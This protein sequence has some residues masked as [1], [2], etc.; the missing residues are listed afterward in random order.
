MSEPARST[1]EIIGTVGPRLAD[2]L[3]RRGFVPRFTAR[4]R[5]ALAAVG[6]R[7]A[8]LIVV[9]LPI[10]DCGGR[11]LV[12]ELLARNPALKIIVVG[13][14]QELRT[15]ADA[16]VAGA[17]EHVADLDRGL[18]ML[19]AAVGAA[20]G[21][22]SRKQEVAHSSFASLAA[23]DPNMRRV[24]DLVRRLCRRNLERRSPPSVLLIG[25]PGTG[26][27]LLAHTIHYGGRRRN[28]PF[29]IVN[30]ARLP[31]R[32]LERTLLSGDPGAGL[33][34]GARGGTLFV[35]EVDALPLALQP[36]LLALLGPANRAGNRQR[37][38]CVDRDV[39]LITSAQPGIEQA[40]ASGGFQPDLYRRLNVV[41]IR[42]PPLRAR[43]ID[44][45][46][47]AKALLD[48]LCREH[49]VAAR[50]FADDACDAIESHDWPGNVRE[51][52]A[53][54]ERWLLSSDEAVIHASD[55]EQRR[56]A[57]RVRF[58]PRTREVWLELPDGGVALAAVERAALRAALARCDG[59]V[60]RAARFL[61][62]SRHTMI[63]RMKK[64]ALPG[65][66]QSRVR[67]SV[68]SPSCGASLK[69]PRD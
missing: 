9:C 33:L 63:Y 30:C 67:D 35:D 65:P 28:R 31:A 59:N 48:E 22:P 42:I 40:V 24:L 43:S 39:Q 54:I 36:R 32:S 64:F 61:R 10:A 44:K 26:K 49:G 45:L 19:L 23:W 14:D 57:E 62:I 17:F 21:D 3:A 34:D 4:A 15:S 5:P 58:D 55:L 37:P 20:L 1:I 68:G 25:E 41:S 38:G 18:D 29:V 60:T 53:Q 12:R 27:G 50:T 2:G 69:L 13:S 11:R 6:A 56:A 7:G 47:L 66:G 8:S 51:L 46:L 52:R 16:I